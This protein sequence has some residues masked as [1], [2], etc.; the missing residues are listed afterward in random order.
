MGIKY[1][2]SRYSAETESWRN[3]IKTKQL[4]HIFEWMEGLIQKTMQGTATEPWA[5][6]PKM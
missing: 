1:T 4:I 6:N 2:K 5:G 3:S